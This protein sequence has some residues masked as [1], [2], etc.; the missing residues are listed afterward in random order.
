[1]LISTWQHFALAYPI[2]LIF[3]FQTNSLTG[4]HVIFAVTLC[5]KSLVVIQKNT[6]MGSDGKNVEEISLNCHAMKS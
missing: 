1:M 2:I 3:I 5:A 6:K 4:G